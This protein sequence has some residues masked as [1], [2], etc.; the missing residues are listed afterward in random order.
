MA[1]PRA[2]GVLHLGTKLSGKRTVVDRLYQAGSSKYLF[3][4]SRSEGLEAVFLNT[5]GGVT[6]GDAFENSVQTKAGTTLTLTT[7]A[8]ERAYKAQ[9]GQIGKVRNTVQVT[10]GARVNWLPQETILFNDSAMDRQLSVDLDERASFLMVEPLIFGRI[11]MGEILTNIFFRDRIQIRKKGVPVYVDSMT[12]RGDVNAHLARRFIA[13]GA[14]AMASLV[15][16]ADDAQAY[17][18]KVRE[19]LP[20]TGG[21]SLL[22]DDTLVLRMLATDSFDLRQTL[23]P[24]ISLLT[25][26]DLPIC[27][28]I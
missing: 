7:Q 9:P 17:L 24:V 20:E 10:S 23:I 28:M 6:G 19:L 5:A 27:W 1:Q 22:Y 4:R 3:P 25:G 26:Q 14:L 13:N 8:C 18:S 11:A 12:L 2:R 16:I 15:Y 21:A